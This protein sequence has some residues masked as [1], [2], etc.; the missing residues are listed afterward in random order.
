MDKPIILD[1]GMGR[2]LER[3]GAPFRQPEWSALSLIE[4]PDLVARAHGNFIDAGE[5]VITTNCYAVLPFHIGQERFDAHGREWIKR[6]AVLAREAVDARNKDVKIAGSLPPLFGSYRPDLFDP[7]LAPAMLDAFIEEQAPYV[8]FW[9]AETL[10]SRAEARAVCDALVRNGSD[11]PLWIAYCPTR[12]DWRALHQGEG[13]TGETIGDVVAF[14]RD[15]TPAEAILYNCCPM[16]TAENMIAH[17]G[18][19]LGADRTLMIGAYPN[20]FRRPSIGANVG[21]TPLRT[22][23]VTP[24]EYATFAKRWVDAG[25]DIVGGCCGVSPAHIAAIDAGDD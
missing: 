12:D 11:L 5:Q 4:T 7:A 3:M 20:L 23:D 8:D 17:T 14:T 25:A 6:S 10:C 13:E 21:I 2:E 1:G 24:E 16:E 22:D 19:L 9:L 18:A 15:E